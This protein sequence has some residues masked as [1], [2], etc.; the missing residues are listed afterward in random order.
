MGSNL[1][2]YLKLLS[3]I[4]CLKFSETNVQKIETNNTKEI[5]VILCLPS[6]TCSLL[7]PRVALSQN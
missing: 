6:R 1:M 5:L 3:D 7:G 2:L 4:D